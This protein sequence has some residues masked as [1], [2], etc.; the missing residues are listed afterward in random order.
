MIRQRGPFCC[1]HLLRTFCVIALHWSDLLR[2]V[3][4]EIKEHYSVLSEALKINSIFDKT[5]HFLYFGLYSQFHN[6]R[7]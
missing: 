1:S 7:P 2:C 4:R 3:K 6:R 5:V